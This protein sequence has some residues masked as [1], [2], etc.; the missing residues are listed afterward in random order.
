MGDLER[1]QQEAEQNME[2]IDGAEIYVRSRAWKKW[3]E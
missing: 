1:P 2:F 3:D